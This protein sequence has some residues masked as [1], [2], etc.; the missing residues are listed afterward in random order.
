ML[1]VQLSELW[2]ACGPR[3]I[4]SQLLTIIRIYQKEN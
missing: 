2:T 1:E 3:L 4:D